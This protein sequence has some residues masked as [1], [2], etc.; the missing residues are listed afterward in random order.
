M[1]GER[2]LW[3]T[4]KLMGIEEYQLPNGLRVVLAPDPAKPTFT[5]NLTVLVGSIHEGA[6]EAGMAHVFEH[7]LFHSLKGFPDVKETFNAMG[8]QCNGTTWF[9]RT[10]FFATMRSSEEN[11]ETAIR[12]EAAR[13]GGATLHEEDLVKEGKIVESEFEMR[14]TFPQS[15]MMRGM[16]GCMFDFHAYSREPIGTIEDFKSLKM[17]GI[18]AFYQRYY[19]PDNAVLFLTGKFDPAKALA[20]VAKHFKGLKKSKQGRPAY[21]TREP[22][23]QG[24][25]RY[26]VRAAGDA[27]HVMVGYRVPGASTPDAAVADVLA[28]ALIS[29][30]IGPVHDALVGKG[31][32]SI[33]NIFPMDLRMPSPWI[34]MAEVP[35]E[36][37][38]D[39]AEAALI[40]AVERGAY[41]LTQADLDRIKSGV[42][43]FRDQ[44]FNNPEALADKFGQFEANGS[45]KLLIVR[46]EQIKTVTLEDIKTFATQYLRRENRIIGRFEPDAGAIVVLPGRECEIG[47]YS[48]LLAKVP[49]DIKSTKE[50]SY[51][52]ACLQAALAWVDVGPARIGLISK[53][54]KGDDVLI[55]LRIPFAARATV[56]GSVCAGTALGVLMTQ[57][58]KTLT[59]EALERTLADSNSHIGASV[60][61]DGAQFSI[62]TKL[63]KLESILPLALEML[64]TPFVQEQEIHDYVARREGDLKALQD[65]PQL[66]L[67]QEVNRMLYHEGDPRRKETVDQQIA[68]LRS[69]TPDSLMAF[70]RD[71]FGTTGLVGSVVGD[72]S[73]EDVTRLLA[74]LVAEGWNASIPPVEDPN[75]AVKTV[76]TATAKV[77]TPGKPTVFNALIHPLSASSKGPDAVPMEAIAWLLFQDPLASRIPKKIR[78]EAALSYVVQGQYVADLDGDFSFVMILTVTNPDN[79][80]RSVELAIAEI[81]AALKD[82]FTAD[83]VAA[84]KIAQKSRLVVSRS[85]D[86]MIGAMILAL[87]RNH[88]DFGLWA[89]QD[90][91]L[92]TLTAERVND[93]MRRHYQPSK[94]GLVQIGDLST[95]VPIA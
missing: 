10:N 15:L 21:T 55:R 84:F 64:R 89:T 16:L 31:L 43:R 17:E 2:A 73:P 80:G 46:C 82:G 11:L 74:P 12:L 18:K 77:P 25:R 41:S 45:W 24:E 49:A 56:V 20:L 91:E 42:E 75:E 65:N 5:I 52:P 58:T 72:L 48:D 14:A 35:R 94:M 62:Q 66:M 13:L 68:D 70:H 3:P 79:A 39:A 8:A 47:E 38:P 93:A 63:D 60:V 71:F 92:E 57:R 28:M 7:L 27:F 51:T 78:G 50:F 90:Q 53:E 67:G 32:A 4:A 61:L 83:E 9:D 59:K 6:G 54:V 69:L 85:D 86:N 40:V 37:D 76:S 88:L 22:G 1:K 23:A 87:G 19:T 81:E 95:A 26:V 33:A 30:R 44:I 29:D 36:K 34:A